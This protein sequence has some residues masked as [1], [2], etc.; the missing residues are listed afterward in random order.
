MF[1]DPAARQLYENRDAKDAD[2]VGYLRRDAR[3]AIRTTP[4]WPR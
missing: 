3:G 4:R 1:L 2:A